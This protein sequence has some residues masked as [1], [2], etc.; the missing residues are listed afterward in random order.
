VK[1]PDLIENYREAVPTLKALGL[2][3]GLRMCRTLERHG[4]GNAL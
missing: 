3:E 1:V 2:E 4:A